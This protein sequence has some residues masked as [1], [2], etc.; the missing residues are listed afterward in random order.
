MVQARTRAFYATVAHSL[1]SEG[2]PDRRILRSFLAQEQ[3]DAIEVLLVAHGRYAET[4]W[5]DQKG[6]LIHGPVPGFGESV[7]TNKK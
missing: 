3:E 2:F 5:V 6:A 4:V 7:V 1:E